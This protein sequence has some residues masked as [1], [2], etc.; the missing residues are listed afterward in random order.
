MTEEEVQALC[1]EEEE[2]IN[3]WRGSLTQGQV[4]SI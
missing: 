1:D 2:Y 4:E 3:R